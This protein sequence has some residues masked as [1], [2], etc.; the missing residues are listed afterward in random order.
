MQNLLSRTE[1]LFKY[2]SKKK[3]KLLKFETGNHDNHIV[4]GRYRGYLPGT[5]AF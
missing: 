2:D 5:S 3:T 1:V 4:L